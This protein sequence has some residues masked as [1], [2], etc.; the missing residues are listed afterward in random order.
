MVIVDEDVPE[1]PKLDGL[2]PIEE[3]AGWPE[4]VSVM[5]EFK[6]P[7][8]SAVTVSWGEVPA[9]AV[10]EDAEG[11]RVKPTPCE[12]LPAS[13]A[14]RPALGLPQPVTRS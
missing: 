7:V 11:D 6:V 14:I 8:T 3:P 2:K 10:T 9:A 12:L 4:Y 5:L 13:A 1:L